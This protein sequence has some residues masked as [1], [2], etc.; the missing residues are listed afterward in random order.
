MLVA[1]PD[2]HITVYY[3]IK[4]HLATNRHIRGNSL[5]T[6]NLFRS[7]FAH[8]SIAN[9]RGPLGWDDDCR[10]TFFYIVSFTIQNNTI[11]LLRRTCH[12]PF[13]NGHPYLCHLSATKMRTLTSLAM[14]GTIRS[15]YSK[16]QQPDPIIP[17]QTIKTE[18]IGIALRE[19]IQR[20]GD[21]WG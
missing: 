16:S 6:H 21:A 15:I 10:R 19:C 14:H 4:G 20:C 11:L 9:N 8:C 2:Y 18:S 1:D 3:G 17:L 5:D 7:S 12:L 13:P